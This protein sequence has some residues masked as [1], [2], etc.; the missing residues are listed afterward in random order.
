MLI[1]SAVGVLAIDAGDQLTKGIR[2][3]DE[4]P[5]VETML[6][7]GLERVECGMPVILAAGVAINVGI[8]REGAESLL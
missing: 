6:E 7:A 1:S 8:L 3:E 2:R 4:Q 5:L